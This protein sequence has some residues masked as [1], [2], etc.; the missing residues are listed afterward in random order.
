MGRTYAGSNRKIKAYLGSK[1]VKS[2]WYGNIRVYPNAGAVTYYVDNGIVYTEEVDIDQSCLTPTTFT[3]SKSGWTF[4]GWKETSVADSDVLSEKIMDGN[5]Y[6]LYAVF[7]QN[8]T[9]TKYDGSS[10]N[11]ESKYRYYNNTNENNPVF[12]LTQSGLS[13]WTPQGWCSSNSATAAV[14]VN[15]GGNV[16]LNASATYYAKYGQTIT[17]SYNG[18]GATGGST[19]AQSNTRYYNTGNYSNPSFVLRS[20]GF[21][22]SG[23]S[24]QNWA[25]GSASGTKYSAGATVTLSANATF[26]ATWKRN[27]I[28]SFTNFSFSKTGD[29]IWGSNSGHAGSSSHTVSVSGK[30]LLVSFSTTSQ[31]GGSLSGRTGAI[32]LNGFTT[33]TV[34]YTHGNRS[35]V[36]IG[37]A[38]GETKTIYDDGISSISFNVSGL[39]SAALSASLNVSINSNTEI[40]SVSCS[41]T[42]NSISLS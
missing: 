13:G 31:A 19:A 10:S 40:P 11:T 2:M 32:D 3:P 8:V 1:K 22:K 7:E 26:Y 39:N 42:V 23:W 33:A 29:T 15:N 4:I 14:I 34:N 37:F 21:S 41:F 5:N 25:M 28:P 9:V 30:T 36:T 18:N 12:T 6:T 27:S 24:F 17:L 20:S 38:G 16:T 35:T